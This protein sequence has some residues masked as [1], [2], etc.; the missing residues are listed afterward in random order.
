MEWA[1]GYFSGDRGGINH[2]GRCGHHLLH[3]R[4]HARATEEGEKMSEEYQEFK[5]IQGKASCLLDRVENKLNELNETFARMDK[6]CQKV[7]QDD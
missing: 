5:R 7:N 2:V 4:D 6:R 3:W 1:N